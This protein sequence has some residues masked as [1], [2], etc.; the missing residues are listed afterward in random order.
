[1]LNSDIKPAIS[2]TRCTGFLESTQH[3]P[4]GELLELLCDLQQKDQAGAADV[5]EAGS[6]HGKPPLAL[7]YPFF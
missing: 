7:I 4:S 6:I 5:G 1:M 2:K 3:H